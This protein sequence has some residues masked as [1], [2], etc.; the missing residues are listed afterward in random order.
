MA[1][2]PVQGLLPIVVPAC[3]SSSVA[4]ALV[5]IQFPNST[6]NPLGIIL[7]ILVGCSML[8]VAMGVLGNAFIDTE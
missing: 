7:G 8:A 2:I 1:D 3:I 5:L 4:S 6:S